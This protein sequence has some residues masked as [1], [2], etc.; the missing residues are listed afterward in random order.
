ML[1]RVLGR[2]LGDIKSDTPTQE[3]KMGD[4]VLGW[5]DEVVR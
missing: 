4:S 2:V 1:G 5:G 3:V